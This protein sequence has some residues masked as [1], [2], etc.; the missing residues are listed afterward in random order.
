[1]TQVKAETVEEFS[2]VE[3]HPFTEKWKRASIMTQY[4]LINKII[5]TCGMN[6]FNPKT[7]QTS[8]HASLGTH[9]RGNPAQ[10]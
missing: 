2:G 4:G 8:V 5:K 6:Y 10:H 9:K 3:M 7:S 1:M